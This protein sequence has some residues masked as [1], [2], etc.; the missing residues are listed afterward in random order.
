MFA[1]IDGTRFY[2]N[3]STLYKPQ[4]KD[5]PILVTAGQGIVIAAN[6][7]SSEVNLKKFKPIW[8]QIDKLQ[9]YHGAVFKANFST[10]GH[11]SNAFQTCLELNMAGCRSMRYS[12]DESFFC[13]QHL[14]DIGVDMPSY[15]QKIRKKVYKET[16]VATG[17]GVG[18]SLT[19]AKAA[20]WAA[21][22]VD[23]YNGQCVLDSCTQ[24][25]AILRM[26]PIKQ[27]W[28]VGARLSEHLKRD[29]L[30]MAFQ[31]KQCEPK[32]YQKRYGINVANIIHELNS[33]PVL[34][35]D[36]VRSKKKQIWSTSS[37]RDR[38][39]SIEMVRAEIAHHT[40]E[41]MRKVRI[42]ESETL[43]LSIFVSTSIHDKCPAFNNRIDINFEQGVSDTS[44]SLQSVSGAIKS[45]L[46][47]CLLSQP[48]YKVGVG[49]NELIDSGY[50]KQFEL[51]ND[52][53]N[54]ESLNT[55]VDL[56]NTRFGK[57]TLTFGSETR[58]YS[59]APGQI[60]M[61]ELEDYFTDYNKL[62]SVKCI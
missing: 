32:I 25:D 55:T 60:R 7:K 9:L 28:G 16:G 45:L 14:F 2:A 62:L 44:F 10:L 4:Y 5:K 18:A 26:M 38:L 29:G 13:V 31:L 24:I 50:Q 57:G 51:F 59:E 6:R 22:N 42:Q 20:S 15:I 46:P 30:A 8:S 56:L 47:V 54:K 36:H 12:V 52:F 3:S 43:T 1:L 39:R 11:L 40:S 33:V 35:F 19:L 27:V 21:K 49:A 34:D 58:S 61:Q 53:D 17:A 37:Y 41:V 48:I 23:G